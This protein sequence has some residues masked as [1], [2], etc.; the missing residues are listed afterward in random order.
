V[1]ALSDTPVVFL[2]GARQSGKST[3]ALGLARSSFN[4]G[5][6]TLDSAATLSA[7]GSDPVGFIAGLPK[8]AIINEIQRVP[9]ELL[10]S[11]GRLGSIRIWS[12]WSSGIS[13]T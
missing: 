4:A 9:G 11:A 8:P 7:A 3:L 5:Y 13:E 1:E 6:F 12:A 2:R 10:R